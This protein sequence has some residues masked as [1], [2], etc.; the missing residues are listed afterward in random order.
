M[1]SGVLALLHVGQGFGEGY[2]L[3]KLAGRGWRQPSYWLKVLG[4]DPAAEVQTKA[5]GY[6]KQ[7]VPST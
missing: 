6:E 1:G 5:S 4:T 7:A 3:R 2:T